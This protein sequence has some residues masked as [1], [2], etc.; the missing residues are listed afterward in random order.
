[1][2]EGRRGEPA[3]AGPVW[4][5][6]LKPVSRTGIAGRTARAPAA[7]L[8]G[9][10]EG[11]L[12]VARRFTVLP[13]ATYPA[14][15]GHNASVQAKF[16]ALLL[17]LASPAAVYL[18]V[19]VI[20]DLFPAQAAAGMAAVSRHGLDWFWFNK[21]DDFAAILDTGRGPVDSWAVAMV[22]GYY[23]AWLVPFV[24]TVA[25]VVRGTA[26]TGS[27]K[28]AVEY[29][30]IMLY[31]L[32]LLGTIHYLQFGIGPD[33]RPTRGR[34]LLMPSQGL[35]LGASTVVEGVFFLATALFVLA[36]LVVAYEMLRVLFRRRVGRP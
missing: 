5:R 23:A 6:T 25:H 4:R 28:G 9:E 18:G 21:G 12:P 14:V 26:A 36:T 32:G 33:A 24:I 35:G 19:K 7:S 10:P 3:V 8:P 29:F 30:R 22:A 13:V 34:L 1:M 20:L 15:M 2:S 16:W 27:A 31:G 11:R 17:V